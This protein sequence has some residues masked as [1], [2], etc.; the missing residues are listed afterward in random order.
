MVRRVV[1]GHE[2]LS[3]DIK[4]W[5]FL[6]PAMLYCSASQQSHIDGVP[7]ALQVDSTVYQHVALTVEGKLL[8]WSCTRQE[9]R[10]VAAASG[11][12]SLLVMDR[13][14]EVPTCQ[15]AGRGGTGS[16]TGA[17]GC[18]CCTSHAVFNRSAGCAEAGHP[19][20]P[21]VWQVL[22]YKPN[23]TDVACGQGHTLAL[24]ETGQVR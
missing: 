13:S 19:D 20:T 3:D 11:A 1:Q 10:A 18:T 7:P 5:V 15:T 16:I 6:P 17:G 24:L 12:S 4:Y 21:V 23:V 14:R 9:G 22:A 2:K 8:T